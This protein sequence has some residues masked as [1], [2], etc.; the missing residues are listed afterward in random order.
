MQRK[1]WNPESSTQEKHWLRHGSGAS[2]FRCSGKAF[3]LRHRHVRAHLWSH[4]KSKRP[5]HRTDLVVDVCLYLCHIGYSTECSSGAQKQDRIFCRNPCLP[6]QGHH[7]TSFWFCLRIYS[8]TLVQ[9]LIADVDLVM[10][11]LSMHRDL[12]VY[13][14]CVYF[15]Q[16]TCLYDK[17]TPKHIAVSFLVLLNRLPNA[18]GHCA[19][20]IRVRP[21]INDVRVRIVYLWQLRQVVNLI[22]SHRQ[23]AAARTLARWER[24]TATAST[25]RTVWS[26]TTLE[27]WPSPSPTA[28]GRT[29]LA[30]GESSPAHSFWCAQK[31]AVV[32]FLLL[33]LFG[34]RFLVVA[35]CGQLLSCVIAVGV[36]FA[37][38]RK[39]W[40]VYTIL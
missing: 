4:P 28:A 37:W 12:V 7:M 16:L 23:Q 11:F 6:A 27:H 5:R 25:W 17:R 39:A 33:L 24:T 32:F 29:T 3:Q 18:L 35:F 19:D 8:W 22:A 20:H 9:S 38:N 31:F 14:I 15:T 30:E 21:V 26:P 36:R 40:L 2:G 10:W 13:F 1:W 34:G